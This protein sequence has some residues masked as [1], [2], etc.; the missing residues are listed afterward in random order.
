MTTD[1]SQSFKPAFAGFAAMVRESFARQG[2]MA[3]LGAR[4]VAVE[5]GFCA[6]E[7]SFSPAVGQQQGVF[8]G[9]A[10]G[11]VGEVASG[12]A[13]YTLMPEDADIVSVEYKINLVRAARPP[14]VRAEGRVLRTGR[15]LTVVRGEVFRIDGTSRELCAVLQA[16]MMRVEPST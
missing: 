1:A 13:A 14:L 2:L 9:G 4:L 3:T 10:I 11:A 7:M 6:I 16:T 15:T 5:P 12:L 8:H